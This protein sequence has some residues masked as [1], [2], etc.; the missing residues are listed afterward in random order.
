MGGVQGWV[1]G[2]LRGFEG[3]NEVGD[4]E[5]GEVSIF[6]I[7]RFYSIVINCVHVGMEDITKKKK[8]GYIFLFYFSFRGI[9]QNGE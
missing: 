4:H 5:F 3:P 8:T 7:A 2:L 9:G 6:R 1:K